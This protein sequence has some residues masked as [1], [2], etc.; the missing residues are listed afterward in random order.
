MY[1]GVYLMIGDFHQIEA[2]YRLI[3]LQ[4]KL[5][6]DFCVAFV[7]NSAEKIRDTIHAAECIFP[8]ERRMIIN[9]FRQVADFVYPFDGEDVFAD[10]ITELKRKHKYVL[11]YSMAQDINGIGR[12]CM[13]P[14]LCDY[15]DLFNIGAGFMEC[16]YG[17]SKYLMYEMTRNLPGIHF[18]KT[19]YVLSPGD[20][21][22]I[23]NRPLSGRW[24]L[25][26][27]DESASIGMEV[28]CPEEY[29]KEALHKKLTSYQEDYPI[30][31]IQ[32]YIEGDEVA[33]PLFWY[34]GQYYCPGISA[35]VFH[36]EHHFLD[37]DTICLGNCSYQE[38]ISPLS[39][40]LIESSV[41]VASALGYRAISRIDYRIKNGIGYI[42]DIGPNPTISEKNGAN[43]LF[44]LRLQ[45][46]GSCVYQLMLY[47]ALE[48]HGLFKPSFDDTPENW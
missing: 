38:Y 6:R 39:S 33:V 31:C 21:E 43:E 8:E 2:I 18:P 14:L 13:V 22:G 15:Y 5:D 40:K 1:K 7:Y 27:N 26:P 37:Y 47:S 16:V 30:F 41:Q 11:V 10:A 12:R 42:E 20:L 3:C 23:L 28:F 9:S 44:R 24:L 46:P 34:G 25:K 17:G 4:P 36:T 29:S 32:E 48:Q 19:Y 35:V 45:A